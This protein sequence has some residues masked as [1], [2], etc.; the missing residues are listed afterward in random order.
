MQNAKF[1]NVDE[2]QNMKIGGK[3]GCL[4]K[5]ERKVVQKADKVIVPSEYLKKVVLRWGVE[6]KNVEVIYNEV[7][8]IS[9]VPIKHDGEKWLVSAC[10]LVS[11]KGIDTLIEVISDISRQFPESGWKLKIVGDGPE[12][13]NLSKKITDENLSNIVQL[14]G[15]LSKEKTLAYMASADVF[16]LNSGYEGFSHVL[17]EAHNQGVPVIAS[18]AGGNSEVVA[19]P[20]LFEFNNKKEIVEKV[21]LNST[22]GKRESKRHSFGNDMFNDTKQVLKE[23]CAN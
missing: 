5:I 12:M 14:T 8:Y 13:N 4:K 6:E 11:W 10:R 23:V 18:N 1:V 21:L 22:L 19:Y 3:I 17:I 9:A 16:V 15:N 2:F 20:A 7:E